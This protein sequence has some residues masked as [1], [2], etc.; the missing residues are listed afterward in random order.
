[1]HEQLE[2]QKPEILEKARAVARGTYLLVETKA[3]RMVEGLEDGQVLEALMQ[4]KLKQGTGEDN[5]GDC[6][7]AL[8]QQIVSNFVIE[9]H[10]K[11]D[12]NAAIAAVKENVPMLAAIMAARIYYHPEEGSIEV[13]GKTF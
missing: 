11:D 8:A 13:D 9:N 7:S 1:M 5:F 12:Q 3:L 10:K 4:E 6:L 2:S